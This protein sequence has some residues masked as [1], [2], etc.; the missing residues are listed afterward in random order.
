MHSLELSVRHL[1]SNLVKNIYMKFK[2]ESPRRNI[3][4]K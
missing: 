1:V 3:L 4:N 2:C